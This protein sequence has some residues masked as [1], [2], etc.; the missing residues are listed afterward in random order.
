LSR[1]ALSSERTVIARILRKHDRS[2]LDVVGVGDAI[3]NR[4]VGMP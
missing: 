1:T 2:D 4:W 3:E